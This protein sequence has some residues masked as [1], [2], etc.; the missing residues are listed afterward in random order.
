MGMSLQLCDVDSKVAKGLSLLYQVRI[1]VFAYELGKSGGT[2]DLAKLQ[3]PMQ[4][5][6]I[7]RSRGSYRGGPLF[8]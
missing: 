1:R 7:G 3:V 4:V 2:H 8:T 6:I 5:V